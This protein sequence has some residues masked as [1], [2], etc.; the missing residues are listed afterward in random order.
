MERV[1][2][3]AGWWN[4]GWT[5]STKDF[6]RNYVEYM[7]SAFPCCFKCRDCDVFRNKLLIITAVFHLVGFTLR[8]DSFGG[9]HGFR[10]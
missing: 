7:Y 2:L 3:V 5:K 6:E 4:G 1:F 10:V 8:G 9:V